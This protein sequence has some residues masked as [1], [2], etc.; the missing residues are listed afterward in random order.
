MKALRLRAS[1]QITG[2]NPASANIIPTGGDSPRKMLSKNAQK[3]SQNESG[4]EV[5][6]KARFEYTT[7]TNGL[8]HTLL[9]GCYVRA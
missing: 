7:V 4:G 1:F 6:F 3:N 9:V 2:P 8:S 5:L